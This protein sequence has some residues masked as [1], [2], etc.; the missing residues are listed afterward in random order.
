MER[1]YKK[2]KRSFGIYGRSKEDIKRLEEVTE[3]LK[4]ICG[5]K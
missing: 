1:V 3:R 4:A 5:Y 2:L